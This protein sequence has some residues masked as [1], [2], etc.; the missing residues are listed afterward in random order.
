MSK[1]NI[2]EIDNIHSTGAASSINNNFLAIQSII[3]S[4]LSR[5]G[6]APNFMDAVL[7]M[8]GYNI[9]NVGSILTSDGSGDAGATYGLTYDGTDQATELQAVL[10]SAGTT[11]E[12]YGPQVVKLVSNAGELGIGARV[13]VPSNVTL[14]TSLIQIKLLN[15]GEISAFGDYEELPAANLFRLAA[16]AEPGDTTITVDAS[17]YGSYDLLANDSFQVLRGENDANGYAIQRHEY[18]QVSIDDSGGISSLVITIDP[19]IPDDQGTFTPINEGSAWEP[20]ETGIDRSLIT[21]RTSSLVDSDID[22]GDVSFDV[23]DGSDFGAGDVCILQDDRLASDPGNTDD[24]LPIRQE[25]VRVRSVATNTITLEQRVSRDFLTSE[26]AVLIKVNPVVNAHIIGGPIEKGDAPAAA[27]ASRKHATLLYLADSCSIRDVILDEDAHTYSIRGQAARVTRSIDCKIYNVKRI[28]PKNTSSSDGIGIGNFYSTNTEMFGNYTERCRHGMQNQGSTRANRHN[29]L[30]VNN[31]IN[32]LDDHGVY[33][34]DSWDHDNLM[35]AG[36]SLASGSTQQLGATYGNTRWLEGTHHTRVSGNMFV[37]FSGASDGGIAVRQASDD[38]LIQDNIFSVCTTGVR[39][40]RDSR[41]GV[42]VTTDVTI[43]DNHF[44]DCITDIS[45]DG[46]LDLWDVATTYSGTTNRPVF[47]LASN[48]REYS[49]ATTKLGGS[50]PTHTS[51]TTDDWL[52]IGTSINGING[53]KIYHNDSDSGTNSID[54]NTITNYFPESGIILKTAAAWTADTS[55]ILTSAQIGIETDTGKAK[56]GDNTNLWGSLS[57]SY[58]LTINVNGNDRTIIIRGDTAANWS[59]G[60]PTLDEFEIGFDSTNNEIRIGDGSTAWSGLSPIGGSG[61]GVTTVTNILTTVTAAAT[62]NS[63]TQVSSLISGSNLTIQRLFVNLGSPGRLDMPKAAAAN[64]RFILEIAAASEQ[65][66]LGIEDDEAGS[67]VAEG[68]SAAAT[69]QPQSGSVVDWTV[70]SNAGTAPVC[71]CI[72]NFLNEERSV[73]GPLRVD[74]GVIEPETLVIEVFSYAES[75]TTGDGATYFPIPARL[76][77]YDLTSISARVGV[78]ATG[79]G[80]ETI[81]IV[82]HNSTSAADMATVEVDEDETSSSTALSGPTIDTDEDDVATDDLLRVDIDAVPGSTPGDGL[83]LT[84][85][86]EKPA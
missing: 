65:V 68:K 56:Q 61:G 64:T 36:P 86:F 49:T 26:N 59:S 72:G 77:G 1:V 76:N 16:D 38:V 9:I 22:R 52:H 63:T 67:S 14:D 53:L 62:L 3:D 21:V 25:M 46:G 28:G 41:G 5:T 34:T 18:R 10:T 84:L 29:N 70:M 80:S 20:G 43:R 13:K 2:T 27:P 71:R 39:V 48:G 8:N 51:G 37:G 35:V 47:I 24:G 66:T 75:I 40:L 50:E 60:D 55:T 58:Q 69:L 4:L 17:D 79:S 44:R 15:E 45:A 81:D 74:S 78:A 31:L 33:E 32:T 42:R 83:W 73:G 23:A 85:V 19:P 57:Y 30:G 6:L 12:T 11:A 54:T 82:L 7:D